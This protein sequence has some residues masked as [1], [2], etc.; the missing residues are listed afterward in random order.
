MEIPVAAFSLFTLNEVE[1]CG[2]EVI[3]QLYAGLKPIQ[4]DSPQIRKVGM[5]LPLSVSLI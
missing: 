4:G 3:L 2:R 1:L 5:G